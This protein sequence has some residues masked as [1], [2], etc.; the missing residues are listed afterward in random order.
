[1]TLSTRWRHLVGEEEEHFKTIRYPRQ[2]I[3][4]AR[5]WGGEP[6]GQDNARH[7]LFIGKLIGLAEDMLRNKPNQFVVL[8]A[9]KNPPS[10]NVA[11]GDENGTIFERSKIF[12]GLWAYVGKPKKDRASY[13]KLRRYCR[14]E[15]DYVCL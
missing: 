10:A 3:E 6:W 13:S 5:T 2:V 7:S 4:I 14:K 1:M 12:R 15:E 11:K 9:C 8:L